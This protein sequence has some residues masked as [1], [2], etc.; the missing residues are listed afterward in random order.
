[1]TASVKT[2]PRAIS[3]LSEIAQDYDVLLCDVW[4][5]IH[6]GRESFPAACA[7]LERFGRER[8]PV[9]LISN[10]PRPS[11]DVRPQLD[12]LRVPHSAWS[13]FVSSGDATRALLA[14]RAPGPAWAIGPDRDWP[15]YAGLDLAFTGPEHAA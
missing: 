15:L 14:E 1:M 13:A 8:G 11:S 3:G 6:N 4:G 5:G 9:V 2:A 12:A 7:A 10:A